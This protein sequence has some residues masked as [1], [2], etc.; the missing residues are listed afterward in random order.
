MKAGTA[1]EVLADL[2]P[3][4]HSC[5]RIPFSPVLIELLKSQTPGNSARPKCVSLPITTDSSHTLS[6]DKREKGDQMALRGNRLFP[7]RHRQAVRG[8][9]KP[10]DAG[11]AAT[12]GSGH[13]EEGT[14]VEG[15]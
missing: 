2:G 11:R 6:Q 12:T 4:F 10:G 15:F 7:P 9:Y 1:P 3:E 14:V 5:T 8:C 13:R